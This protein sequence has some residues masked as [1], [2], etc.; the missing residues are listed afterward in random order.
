MVN[1]HSCVCVENTEMNIN[2]MYRMYMHSKIDMVNNTML[3]DMSFICA[4]HCCD[5]C[6]VGLF[7]DMD[8]SKMGA[9]CS[10]E[11]I[12][13]GECEYH[14]MVLIIYSSPFTYE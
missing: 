1:Y 11:Q 7:M 8:G 10:G 12:L 2:W 9:G 5:K 3:M 6:G 13:Y 14:W 4:S